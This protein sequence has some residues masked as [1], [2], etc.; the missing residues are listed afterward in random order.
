MKERLDEQPTGRRRI[1]GKK[2]AWRAKE[3]QVD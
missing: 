3:K 2:G 1:I